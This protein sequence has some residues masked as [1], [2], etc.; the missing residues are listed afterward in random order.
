MQICSSQNID[1]EDTIAELV[2]KTNGGGVR[3]DYA[4]F[5]SE[6]LRDLN[7]DVQVKVEEWLIFFGCLLQTHDY[8]MVIIGLSG[9]S[10][11][12]MRDIYTED[13]SLNMFGLDTEMPY[14]NLSETMQEEGLTIMDLETRQQHYNSWQNLMMDK[15]VP[16]LPLYSPQSYIGT[17]SNLI[18][19]DARWGLVNSLPGMSFNGLHEGQDSADEFR[20]ANFN[21]QIILLDMFTDCPGTCNDFGKFIDE[22][23][24]SISPDLAPTKTGLVID[25]ELIDDFHFKFYMRDEVYWNPSYNITGRDKNSI[26]LNEITESQLLRGLKND[27]YSNGT[28]QKV[29]AKDAVFTFLLWSNPITSGNY[30]YHSWISNIYVDSEDPLAFHIHIDKDPNT[31]ELEYYQDFWFSLNW[32]ILP[33]FFLN[34]SS[35]QVSY[36]SGGAECTGFYDGIYG[37]MP[38]LMYDKTGFGCGKYLLDYFIKQG[39]AV[40]QASPFWMGVN[41]IDG[42]DED[43]DIKTIIFENIP[44][45]SNYP[46]CLLDEFMLGNIDSASL[47]SYPDIRKQ[48]Q[49]D[50]RFNVQSYLGSASFTFLGFNLR[51]PFLGGT[52]NY[53]Y[54]T[55]SGKEDYTVG[56]AIRKAICYAV[57]REEINEIIHNGEYII[58]HSVLYPHAGYFYYD[59]IIKYNYDLDAAKNWISAAGY[60]F[61]V[62]TSFAFSPIIFIAVAIFSLLLRKRNKERKKIGG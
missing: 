44:H 59:E 43:L 37:T 20:L 18:G 29:T 27:E 16:L 8:D 52:K 40:L 45:N 47:T 33:E 36:T 5:I 51:R 56:S 34:S 58:A 1:T 32:L 14:G 9:G 15:I 26:P 55:T 57:D 7:I 19:Y 31:P 23:I 60:S 35:S 22:S 30:C 25:W 10:L 24:V 28:N 46:D 50:P 4:L 21:Y 11:L 41:P 62:E 48:M 3:P 6:Y 17:W 49:A 2:L 54:L 53:E 13:G 12:D 42:L 38:W 39:R 61:P